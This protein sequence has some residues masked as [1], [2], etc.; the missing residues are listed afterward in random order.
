MVLLVDRAAVHTIQ[1]EVANS[2]IN[3]AT[4]ESQFEDL[5]TDSSF[6]AVVQAEYEV[7]LG[8]ATPPSCHNRQTDEAPFATPARPSPTLASLFSEFDAVFATQ[9][10]VAPAGPTAKARAKRA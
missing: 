2:Q 9:T 5:A 4:L 7:T 10:A 3:T 6:Q 1:S 8:L